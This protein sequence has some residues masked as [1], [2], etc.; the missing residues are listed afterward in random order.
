[1]IDT[2]DATLRDE[3]VATNLD[4]HGVFTA[5]GGSLVAVGGNFAELVPP[6]HGVAMTRELSNAE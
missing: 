5:P 1:V 2:K 6:Y 4:F 3:T